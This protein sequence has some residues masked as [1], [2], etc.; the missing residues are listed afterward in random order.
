MTVSRPRSGPAP[1][2]PRS[3]TD[4]LERIDDALENVAHVLALGPGGETI[5]SSGVDAAGIVD[6]ARTIAAALSSGPEIPGDSARCI[7]NTSESC[8]FVY[9]LGKD[10]S[11]IL[12]GPS[13]WNIALTGRRTEQ[14]LV[15]FVDAYLEEMATNAGE[16]A[17]GPLPRRE[18]AE[19]VEVGRTAPASR[20]ERRSR[21]GGPGAD[22]A[23][24]ARVLKALVD[25]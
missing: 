19:D 20:R 15:D 25:L 3:V 16:N 12:V 9:R 17:S 4:V 7:L 6:L 11:V 23:L 21:A 10:L 14:L 13:D 22:H 2:G 1:A 5:G 8:V 18:L 24:L